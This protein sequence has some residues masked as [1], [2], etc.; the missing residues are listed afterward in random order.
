M[1]GSVSGIWLL[2]HGVLYHIWRPNY[3][4]RRWTT[5]SL[6]ME[7]VPNL[8]PIPS[9]QNVTIQWISSRR[10]SLLVMKVVLY[11]T[12][13]KV[14]VGIERTVKVK[15]VNKAI[16]WGGLLTQR[17]TA[18]LRRRS[19]Y[20]LSFRWELSRLFLFWGNFWESLR[21]TG[22]LYNTGRP[23]TTGHLRCPQR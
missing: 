20:Y 16:L 17:Q 15:Y 9:I 19:G 2:G 13:V 3:E 18:P 4:F 6:S 23:P 21:Q 22:M 7:K 1:M 5:Y 8:N 12:G 11:L 14:K 10:S